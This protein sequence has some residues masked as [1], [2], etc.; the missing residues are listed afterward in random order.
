MREGTTN[1]V[2]TAIDGYTHTF[3]ATQNLGCA[4][5]RCSPATFDHVKV[6]PQISLGS[7]PSTYEAYNGTTYPVADIS[8]ITTLNGVNNIFADVGDVSVSAYDS[9]QHYID[10]Q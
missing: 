10:N 2:N 7:S 8:T 5:Y 4:F 1:I 9:I 6:Y 3:T